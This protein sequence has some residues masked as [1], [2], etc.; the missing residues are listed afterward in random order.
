MNLA[1]PTLSVLFSQ[2]FT[3]DFK[4]IEVL[5]PAEMA[6]VEGSASKRKTDFSTGRFC[7]RKALEQLGIDQTEILTDP[8][9]QP[10]WPEGIVGSISHSSMLT[11]AIVGKSRNIVSV[12][13][14]IENIGGVELNMW[15]ILFLESERQFLNSL[16]EEERNIYPTLLFSLKESFYKFQ[17]PLT[18]QFLEFNEVEFNMKDEQISMKVLKE[19]YKM[20]YRL[21]ELQFHWTLADQQLITLCFLKI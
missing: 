9:K 8:G 11:G 16:N 20:E 18:R 13:L 10:I 21:G 19:D 7:A 6:L 5:Y 17:Y 1:F 12:G 2:Y 15:D 4:G 14:D 3:T